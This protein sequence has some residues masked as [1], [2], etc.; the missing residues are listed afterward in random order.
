MKYKHYGKSIP[1][2]IKSAIEMPE[3]EEKMELVRSIANMMKRAYLNW[4][5]DSVNDEVIVEQ[6][7]IMS[8]GQLKVD[9]E[10]QFEST[11]SILGSNLNKKK[12]APKK[13]KSRKRP[14]RKPQQ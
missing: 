3:G 11:R 5:R 1:G 14:F 12:P 9:P 6:L 4:N 13:G 8:D 7:G 10:F 2:Y